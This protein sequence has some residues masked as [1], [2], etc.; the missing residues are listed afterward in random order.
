M[1]AMATLAGAPLGSSLLIRSGRV[2]RPNRK[3]VYGESRPHG[4]ERGE[5]LQSPTYR[6]QLVAV[7]YHPSPDLVRSVSD[8]R[9]AP[10]RCT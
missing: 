10:N 7:L 1:T 3:A 4:L 8:E 2:R 9:I 6:Y 5:R